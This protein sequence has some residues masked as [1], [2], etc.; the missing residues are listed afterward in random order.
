MYRNTLRLRFAC[1]PAN[2]T[3]PCESHDKA[4]TFD[5]NHDLDCEKVAYKRDINK[6]SAKVFKYKYTY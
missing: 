5:V 2:L 3:D 6:M 1:L 4:M